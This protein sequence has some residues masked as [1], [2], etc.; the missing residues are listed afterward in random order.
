MG[1]Y[2]GATSH[3]GKHIVEDAAKLVGGYV[4]TIFGYT[5]I[6]G[7]FTFRRSPSR[8][9]NL[10]GKPILKHDAFEVVDGV[11][12]I[13]TDV[14]VEIPVED[15]GA[16]W[17]IDVGSFH[18][19]LFFIVV[20]RGNGYVATNIDPFGGDVHTIG[21]QHGGEGFAFVLVDNLV[22]KKGF[23]VHCGG[24]VC[25]RGKGDPTGLHAGF[26]VEVVVIGEAAAGGVVDGA[27][28]TRDVL[29]LDGDGV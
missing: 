3:Y 12:G 20:E 6:G 26:V 28:R 7:F 5:H 8:D 4:G 10:F 22:S 15:G 14:H 1:F 19:A 11:L 13:E 2:L 25:D 9:G 23:V 21:N 29:A 16:V 18:N 17:K 24:F 27:A